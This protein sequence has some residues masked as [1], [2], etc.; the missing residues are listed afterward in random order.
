MAGMQ[1]AVETVDRLCGEILNVLKETGE[2]EETVILFTTD[3]GLPFPMM[4]CNLYDDGIGVAFLLRYP[5]MPEKHC[6]SDALLSQVDVFPTLC[7]I[8]KLE[9]PAWL[10]GESFDPVIKGERDEWQEF[11]Q[12]PFTF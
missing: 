7:D 10:Q 4:K 6:V 9:K 2:Y 12:A 1:I 3:H 5:G 8:L 11:C